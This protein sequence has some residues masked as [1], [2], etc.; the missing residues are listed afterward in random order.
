MTWTYHWAAG[1]HAAQPRYN[2]FTYNG[3]AV[4]CGPVA[5][6][7]LFGWADRQAETGNAYWAPRWGLYRRDGGHGAN[8]IA[9]LAMTEGI[10]NVIRELHNRLGTFN[11]FGSGATTPW[12]MPAAS[13]YLTGRSGARI[14]CHWNILGIHEGYIR[15]S[16]IR[17]IRDRATPAIIGTGWLN[18]YPMAYGYAWQKRTVRKT[19]I[20]SWT[21]EVFDQCFY[22][23]QGWGGTGNEWIAASSWFSGT[24][25]P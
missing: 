25:Y 10:R 4:G 14:E 2:Q 16:A 8:D 19:F 23:N 15:D 22:V 6:A 21:E 1:G 18:H 20:F 7:M 5:W 3:F 24:I 17:A 12:S 13:G 9:P 11:L